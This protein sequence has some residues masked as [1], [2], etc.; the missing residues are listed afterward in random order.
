MRKSLL[1]LVEWDELGIGQASEVPSP[2]ILIAQP[3]DDKLDGFTLDR[4]LARYWMLLFHARIDAALMAKVQS[5]EL[6]PSLI[7]ERIDQIGQVEFDEMHSVIEQEDFLLP[8]AGFSETYIE[9]AAVYLQLRYFEPKRLEYFFPAIKD[10]DQ[11]DAVFSQELD[12]LYFLET[13][14]P[15]GALAPEGIQKGR[16]SRGTAKEDRIKIRP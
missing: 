9:A 6:T 13:T 3:G 14:R 16:R 12:V 5:G 2:A 10:Y 1:Q 11:V 7:R 8:P 15:Q 4:L